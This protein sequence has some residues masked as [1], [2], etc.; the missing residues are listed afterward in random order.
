[1]VVYNCYI[2][3]RWATQLIKR[4]ELTQQLNK[5]LE[6]DMWVLVPCERTKRVT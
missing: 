4:V 2:D 6:G 3:K 1:M 5:V